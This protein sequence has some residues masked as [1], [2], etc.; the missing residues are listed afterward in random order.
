M[1]TPDGG[2]GRRRYVVVVEKGGE[3]GAGSDGSLAFHSVYRIPTFLS[4]SPL[5]ISTLF[6]A[7]WST[8]ELPGELRLVAVGERLLDG[9]DDAVCD[10]G[11]E[12]GVLEGRPLD[13]ELGHAPQD[14]ALAQDEQRRRALL[15]LLP[16]APLLLRHLAGR[17]SARLPHGYNL[18]W[19]NTF[20]ESCSIRPMANVSFKIFGFT[21]T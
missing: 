18:Q 11:E 2:R 14:V 13:Q 6:T 10:D 9:E 21:N 5:S 16:V 4:L 8:H 19:L 17:A 12:D 15:L 7:H 1:Q 20:V 3:G